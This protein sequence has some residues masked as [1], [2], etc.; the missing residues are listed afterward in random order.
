MFP[1]YGWS[2]TRRKLKTESG[3]ASLLENENDKSSLRFDDKAKTNILQKQFPN[4]FTHEINYRPISLT[5]I[6]C[7]LME[8]FVR[9]HDA[10]PGTEAAH[11]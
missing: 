8:S 1:F 5:S 9:G 6:L 2:H 4:V 10:P 11:V 7:K 3:V